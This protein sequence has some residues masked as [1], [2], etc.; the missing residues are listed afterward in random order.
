[1]KP[2]VLIVDDEKLNVLTFESFLSGDGYE[3][4]FAEDGIRALELTRTLS[5]DVILLDVMMPG[6][7]GYTVCRQLRADPALGRVPIIMVTAL[8]DSASRLEGLRAGADDFVTKPCSRDEM[9]AR[10]RTIVSLNRF[11]AIAEEKARFERLYEVAPIGIV[12]TD[13]SGAVVAANPRAE[14]LLKLSEPTPLV[15]DLLPRRMG[16]AS[17]I[18]TGVIESALEGEPMPPQAVGFDGATTGTVLRIRA[19]AVPEGGAQRAMLM[20]SDATAEAR[21]REALEKMN[22]ELDDL[23]R[24]RTKQ[25]EEANGLLM[26]YA[27]FVSHD[28]RSP[29]TVVKGYL[30]MLNE[31]VIPLAQGASLVDRAYKATLMMQ[32]LVQ[33]ILQL[34]QDEHEG[35]HSGGAKPTDPKPVIERVWSHVQTVFPQTTPQFTMDRLPEVE[36]SP[37]LIERVFYNLLTNA[38]K[39]SSGRGTPEIHIGA[40]TTPTGPALFV[41]DNGIGF[42]DRDADQLFK[43][44]SRISDPPQGDGFGLGL[45]LVSRLV[46]AHGGRMWAE[47]RAGEGATFHV[48]FSGA[49]EPVA[50]VAAERTA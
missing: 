7:D 40:T 10:V 42:D 4:H 48:Q 33:N 45:S 39:Y 34:A 49:G 21:A 50:G 13:A 17:A 11:R 14:K 19:T 15:G 2:K 32:E 38:V 28:L 1:M 9:R 30:S 41:R 18:I 20:L 8:H 43:E 26:S 25:L 31:G 22:A 23:V 35:A 3:I 27:S 44:F 16:K 46:R 47:G 29:L 12:I 5:P 37:L 36:A 6:M 24:A